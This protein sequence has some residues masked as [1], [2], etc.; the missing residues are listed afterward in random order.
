MPY[1]PAFYMPSGFQPTL[2]G[3]QLPFSNPQSPQMTPPTIHAA[4]IQIEREGDENQFP[5][6]QGTSQMFMTRDDSCII[7]KSMDANGARRTYYDRRAVSAQ[8]AP[9]DPSQYVRRDEIETLI[10]AALAAQKR[11]RR[12]KE[13][14]ENEPV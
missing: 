12:E 3:A 13:P 2:P 4:I 11:G 6:Q 10:S 8:D 5:V 9:F 7:I 1:N 14:V